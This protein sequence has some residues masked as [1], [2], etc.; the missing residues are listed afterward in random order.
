[1]E[2]HREFYTFKHLFSTGIPAMTDEELDLMRSISFPD[3]NRVFCV[4]VLEHKPIRLIPP[5]TKHLDA[6]KKRFTSSFF[7]R[8]HKGRGAEEYSNGCGRG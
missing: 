4:R 6:L 2:L 5:S 1:M 7:A 3:D 8:E